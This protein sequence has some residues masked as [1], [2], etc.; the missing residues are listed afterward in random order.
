MTHPIHF[1]KDTKIKLANRINVQL[2]KVRY[3]RLGRETNYTAGMIQQLS[4]FRYDD[5][6]CTVLMDGVVV[7]QYKTEPWSGA[8]FTVLTTINQRGGSEVKKATLFQSKLGRTRPFEAE[9]LRRLLK[10]IAVKANH[11]LSADERLIKQILDM[12]HLTPHPKILEVLPVDGGIP[13]VVSTQGVFDDRRLQHQK[14]GDW[15]ST[16]V[17]P[18]FDGDTRPGFTS[19][20]LDTRLSKLLVFA[21]TKQS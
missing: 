19:A 2:Q 21:R 3:S 14:F 8:D 10:Q 18:T 6:Y 15:I 7:D 13:T 5:D 9:K 20:V 1:P 16:R 11:E 4:D 12:R 17:L